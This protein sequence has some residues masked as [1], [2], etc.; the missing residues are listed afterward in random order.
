MIDILN[1]LNEN[2]I[3]AFNE[4]QAIVEENNR[5]VNLQN[6]I[7][8]KDL[9]A[10]IDTL[11]QI[12]EENPSKQ[13]NCVNSI[14]ALGRGHEHFHY[15]RTNWERVKQEMEEFRVAYGEEE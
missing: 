8:H 1:W 5:K 4:W 3:T 10:V 2:H 15:R 11:I 7:N 6:R 9:M 12:G 14:L 13:K